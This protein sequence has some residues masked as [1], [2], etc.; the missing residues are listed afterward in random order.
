[1]AT[2]CR[3][4]NAY[5]D[6]LINGIR[7]A[8]PGEDI[9]EW[10]EA[11]DP[12]DIDICVIFR[13]EPG[14]LNPYPN[15]RL[16]SSTGAGIDHYLSDPSLP[17][18]IP[19]VRVV[20]PDSGARM[21][22]YV[23]CWVLFHHRDVAFF[24]AGQAR[25]EWTYKNM[26][27]ARDVTVG[28]MGLGH[29]GASAC[30]RLVAVGYDVA[31]WSRSPKT[32]PGVTGYS[33]PDELA[34]FLG[35]TEILVNLLP[36]TAETRGILGQATFNALPP[37]AVVISAGRGGHL[38]E[39][40]LIVALASGQLRGATI[41]AFSKEPLPSDNPLWTTPNLQI[42]PHSSSTASLETTVGVITSN[43][44]RFRAGEPL[45]NQ[46]DYAKGY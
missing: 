20:D 28:V 29:M 36:L 4:H 6:D 35:R 34:A 33:G 42:T 18:N 10:P 11:G 26:R 8:L 15:L 7:A 3:L 44:R 31:G 14:F 27:S 19:L 25:R 43:I 45:L 38:N 12:N 40:D 39:P 2:L 5:G 21:A 1:M 24:Q 32:L 22:E 13:M 9:R 41:D 37:G 23:L 17:R 46:V 16:I 30:E